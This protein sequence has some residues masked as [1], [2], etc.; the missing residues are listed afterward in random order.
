MLNTYIR[1]VC[2]TY[3]WSDASTI[4]QKL[5]LYFF[6]GKA[7]HHPGLSVPLQPR[8]G[9]LQLTAFP[10]T[11][12]AVEREDIYKCNGHTV[13]KL[14]QRYLTTDW[15][16]PR[17][18]QYGLLWLAAK[19]YQGQ[20]TGSRDVQNRQILSTQPLYSFTHIYLQ[21]WMQ[22]TQKFYDLVALPLETL[23]LGY[24]PQS[25]GWIKPTPQHICYGH[26]SGQPE[27][28]VHNPL[29]TSTWLDT[30]Q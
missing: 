23:F 28:P 25:S 17:V 20:A 29:C 26:M 13:Y 5:Y 3:P 4:R 2:K 1:L 12:I 16:A 7:S 22:V 27:C 21:Q 6:F 11:K 8:F 15:L 10:K 19:L 14:S 30:G 24:Q 18:A 9:F